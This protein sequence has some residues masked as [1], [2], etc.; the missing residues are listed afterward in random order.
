[1]NNSSQTFQD[2]SGLL[3]ILTAEDKDSKKIQ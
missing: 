1:M 3:K 2:E